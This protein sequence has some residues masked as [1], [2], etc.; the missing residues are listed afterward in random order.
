MTQLEAKRQMKCKVDGK[1]QKNAVLRAGMISGD[2]TVHKGVK[3]M[4]RCVKKCC[5]DMKC[6]VAV[7]L[8]RKCYSVR[9][10][11][12]DYCK[13]R[14]AP[15]TT[16]SKTPML[17]FVKRENMHKGTL[18]ATAFS[19]I[20]VAYPEHRFGRLEIQRRCWQWLTHF[21]SVIFCSK[22]VKLTG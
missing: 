20:E 8:E 5:Q 12:E 3:H 19:K 15:P 17:A 13:S 18:I 4:K 2:L 9:C 21:A 10:V 7:M 22:M 1:V 11:N 14:P 16:Y 6:R